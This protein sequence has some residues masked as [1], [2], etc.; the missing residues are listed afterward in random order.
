MLRLG[1]VLLAIALGLI[2]IPAT[3][4]SH[5]FVPQEWPLTLHA[6]ADTH[7][8]SL[9]WEGPYE[10]LL[11]ID[12]A[13]FLSKAPC[14]PGF[15]TSATCCRDIPMGALTWKLRQANRTVISGTNAL[16][17]WCPRGKEDSRLW[18][19]VARVLV[20]EH[21]AYQ[22]E[23]FIGGGPPKF[24]EYRPRVQLTLYSDFGFGFAI[25]ATLLAVAVGFVGV[26]CVAAGAWALMK[27]SRQK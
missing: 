19:R 14:A 2:V 7:P 10:L 17:V 4:R 21:G 25:I 22:L 15:P 8:L 5:A 12:A 20:P 11:S 26:L 27:D 3:V 9:H 16:Q 6:Q 18:N 24:S 23:L 13:D 1:L